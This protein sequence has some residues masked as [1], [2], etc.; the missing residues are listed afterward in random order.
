MQAACLSLCN[1]I[2]VCR[3]TPATGCSPPSA[4]RPDARYSLVAVDFLPPAVIGETLHKVAGRLST[5]ALRPLRHISHSMGSV[6]AAFRQMIQVRRCDGG[7][8]NRTLASSGRGICSLLCTAD[9]TAV[10]ADTAIPLRPIR[11]LPS[12]LQASHVGKVVLSTE[13]LGGAPPAIQPRS[14]PSLA[15]TGGSGDRLAANLFWPRLVGDS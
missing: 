7:L 2:S 13:R 8:G 1:F 5:G 3:S 4:E 15:I 14:C 10:I 11:P 6:A 9:D 12:S